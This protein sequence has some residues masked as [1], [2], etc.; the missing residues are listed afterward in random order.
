LQLPYK[1]KITARRL[2]TEMV[3]ARWCCY[4]EWLDEIINEVAMMFS[5]RAVTQ[6]GCSPPAVMLDHGVRADVRRMSTNRKEKRWN[7]AYC[8]PAR[9]DGHGT[10]SRGGQR[11]AVTSMRLVNEDGIRV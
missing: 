5:S 9:C 11:R 7:L 2:D 8:S 10:R 3:T 4:P 1:E 6:Q